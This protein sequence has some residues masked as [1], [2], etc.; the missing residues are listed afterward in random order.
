MLVLCTPCTGLLELLYST[1]YTCTLCTHSTKFHSISLELLSLN[2]TLPSHSLRGNVHSLHQYFI[3]ETIETYKISQVHSLNHKMHTQAY[4]T[5]KANNTTLPSYS[6][7]SICRDLKAILL[8]YIHSENTYFCS[9]L[10]ELL[11]V[12]ASISVR[13]L[14]SIPL[15]LLP[16]QPFFCF[17]GY[18]MSIFHS[19]IIIMLISSW[20]SYLRPFMYLATFSSSF[21]L[22]PAPMFIL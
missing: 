6:K 21:S 1:K 4:K 9:G 3:R 20:I 10:L 13:T 16:C 17:Q 12:N 7:V 8:Y 18:L 22:C 15:T 19:F 14:S 11:S 5:Q 2:T